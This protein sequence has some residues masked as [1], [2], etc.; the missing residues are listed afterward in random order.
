MTV[1]VPKTRGKQRNQLAHQQGWRCYYC[2]DK[3]HKMT[4][5]RKK[6]TL[7]HKV[8]LSRG[9]LTTQ[10][11]LTAACQECNQKKGNLTEEEFMRVAA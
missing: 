8:P 2:G 9:G 6:T 3:M 10:D 1:S 5:G 7:D 11:N 4:R